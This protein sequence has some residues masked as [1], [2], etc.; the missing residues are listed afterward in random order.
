MAAILCAA[1][2]GREAAK[3]P[4]APA[5]TAPPSTAAQQ[6]R[7]ALQSQATALFQVL[8]PEMDSETHPV[9]AARVALGRALYYETRLSKNQSISC[10]SC[11]DLAQYGVDGQP[12]SLGDTGERGGRN[13]PTTYNAALHIAQ[14]WDGRAADVEAQ[15]KGPVLNPVEMGMPD[16][17]Y[18]VRV[19]KSIPGYTDLFKAAFPEARDPVNYD[20]AAAAIG[21]FERRL[22]T[23]SP[24]DKFLAGDVAALSDVQLAGLNTFI[25]SGCTACHSGVGIGGG[26][27]Q[28]I[29]LVKTFATTDT[30][31]EQVTK[32]PAD[33]FFFK[34]PSL[35]NIEKTGPYFHDGKVVTLNDA[36]SL[37]AE[38]QLGRTLTDAQVSEIM[39]FLGS[40][41]GPIP[42]E[43]IARPALPE[44]GPD[45][46]KPG[47]V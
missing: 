21:A 1:G 40:L 28:K 11:H 16:A 38:H 18:V 26:M 44:S 23:P 43:Y 35:R 45:T 25:A 5:A 22:V 15:A 24:F 46:P 7:T 42:A 39:A 14:F 8:P 3:A 2:C 20:N 27:Y 47:P 31:R 10:N 41:T 13:S 36:V 17:G 6:D 32:N 30:G 4:A 34:V 29:G 37:M 33:R 9:T 12:T 19:L